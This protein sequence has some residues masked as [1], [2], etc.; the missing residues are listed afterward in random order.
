MNTEAG[1]LQGN[2]W[3]WGLQDDHKVVW[4]NYDLK[5][6][7][8][9]EPAVGT[10]AYREVHDRLRGGPSRP[11]PDGDEAAAR[12]RRGNEIPDHPNLGRQSPIRGSSA[13]AA[14]WA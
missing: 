4:G 3:S 13:S 12:S 14:T 7:D 5:D 2:F 10:D 9:P 8:G 11:D 6:E 1:K